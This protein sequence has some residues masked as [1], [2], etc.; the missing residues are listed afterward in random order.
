M[1]APT[2]KFLFDGIIQTGYSLY[3]GMLPFLVKEE[4]GKGCA[5]EVYEVSTETLLDLDFLEGH[6]N[7]YKREKLFVTNQNTGEQSEAFVYVFQYRTDDCD[8]PIWM[9]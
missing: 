4:G 2:S 3:K 8:G 5:A 7:V 1:T 6:P 9:F